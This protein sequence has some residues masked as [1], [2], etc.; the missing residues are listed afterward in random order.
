MCIYIYIH[1]QVCV[2]KSKYLKNRGHEKRKGWTPLFIIIA[3]PIYQF[4]K[5]KPNRQP[6]K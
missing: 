5:Q 6:K 4:R 3:A 2:Y 1:T